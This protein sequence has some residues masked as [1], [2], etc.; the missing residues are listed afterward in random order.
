MMQLLWLV[1]LLTHPLSPCF[2]LSKDGAICQ[3]F[4]AY[5]ECTEFNV[6][7]LKKIIFFW[8]NLTLIGLFKNV[9]T[10]SLIFG[11]GECSKLILNTKFWQNS[12]M[13]FIK[14]ANINFVTLKMHYLRWCSSWCCAGFFSKLIY[15]C[16][17][18]PKPNILSL[19]VSTISMVCSL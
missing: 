15:C 12:V 7:K 11:H 8:S 14:N 9:L 10:I 18:L 6:I 5:L 2:L 13:K 1:L 4:V 3:R 19:G 17:I 16:P